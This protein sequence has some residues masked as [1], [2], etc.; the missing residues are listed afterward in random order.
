V[1]ILSIAM[2]CLTLAGRHYEARQFAAAI[3]REQ[4]SYRVEDLPATF[5]Y[6]ADG[7]ALIR[8]AAR[9]AR[10]RSG[11]ISACCAVV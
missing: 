1:H 11:S 4:P 7:E 3:Q 6:D 2:H 9:D 5:R 10:L 8:R